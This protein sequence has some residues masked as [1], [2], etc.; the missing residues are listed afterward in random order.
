MKQ[1]TSY[2]LLTFILLATQACS[3][4]THQAETNQL[5]DVAIAL[6][7]EMMNSRATTNLQGNA[8]LSTAK[9][10]VFALKTNRIP[11]YGYYNMYCTIGITDGLESIIP[12]T[13][14]SAISFS[15]ISWKLLFV[16]SV[17]RKTSYGSSWI[18]F[19]ISE[20]QH[21]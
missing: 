1:F 13:T 7:Y 21:L 6:T 18:E 14:E 12:S 4:E 16:A 10:G 19:P 5:D 8:L 15:N 3:N 2:I 17:R 11:D 20:L 9:V